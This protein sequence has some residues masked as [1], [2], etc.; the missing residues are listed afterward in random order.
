MITTRFLA[1]A[2]GA[3]L[4][5]LGSAAFAAEPA[6]HVYALG[7]Q[8]NSGEIGT[9]TLT[10][11]GSKTRVDVALANAPAGPQPA[12]IHAGTCAKLDPKPKYPLT[13]VVDGTST[14]TV[15]VPMA[16]LIKGGLAVNVHKSTT[17]LPT[18][19]ACGDLG[20]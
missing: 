19:V 4:L 3:A 10:E 9:V 17:D 11:M 18:Y 7:T 1:V 15:D 5:A 14:T 2:A 20:K 8:S 12:H 6:H 13:S 16:E